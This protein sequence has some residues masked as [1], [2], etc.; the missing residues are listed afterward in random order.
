MARCAMFLDDVFAT[1]TVTSSGETPTLP[2]SNASST[3]P[4]KVYQQ[5][6]GQDGGGS[7]EVKL[8]VNDAVYVNE[9]GGAIT[10]QI[11]AGFYTTALSLI[12]EVAAN[13]TADGTLALAYSGG[14]TAV[15]RKFSLNAS[16]SFILANATTAQNLLTISL[17]WAESNTVNAAAHVADTERS[18]G[19][20]YLKYAQ[21]VGDTVA[22]NLV[23]LILSSVGGSDTEDLYDDVTV[24]ANATD[25][26][27]T[28]VAW[29]AGAS[30]TLAVSER[31]SEA[32]NTLQGAVTSDA[33]G[34]RY[35]VVYWQHVDDK[36]YHRVNVCRAMEAFGSATRQVREITDQN[37]NDPTDSRTLSNQH[38]SERKKWWSMSA[39]LERWSAADYREVMVGAQRYGK[40]NGM[41]WALNWTD[42]L[43]GTVTLNSEADNGLIFYGTI[44]DWS[45]TGYNSSGS[46]RMTGTISFGQLTP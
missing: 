38:P 2:A 8:G 31:P 21:P 24:Y 22:P 36:E 42:I 39:E 46:D 35:W 30:L 18:S 13:L 44:R 5:L 23:S 43:A 37:L 45:A 33:T 9:G 34:Y 25:L 14:Y 27:P 15:T 19:V 11:T 16:G 41:V 12:T 29:A 6:E 20:T 17:G 4:G 26:G 32:E 1:A 7:F 40:T 10:V 3:L 28:Q